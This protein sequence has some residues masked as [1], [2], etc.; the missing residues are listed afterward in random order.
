[1]T[2]RAQAQWLALFD[3]Q[4]SSGLNNTAFCKNKY[5]PNIF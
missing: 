2:R 4:Q 3:E 1:M 5:K